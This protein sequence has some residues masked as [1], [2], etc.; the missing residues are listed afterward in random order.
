MPHRCQLEKLGTRIDQLGD[1]FAGGEPALF[2]LRFDGLCPAALANLFFL[3]LDFSQQINDAA[4]V[5][6]EF[7]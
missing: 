6:F 1:A 3:V 4:G 7:R 5:L 2:V